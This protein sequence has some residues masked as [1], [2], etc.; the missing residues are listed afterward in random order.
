MIVLYDLL[1]MPFKLV[2]PFAVTFVCLNLSAQPVPDYSYTPT[3]SLDASGSA[4]PTIPN[5]PQSA[6]S[7]ASGTRIAY[8]DNPPCYGHAY[9][10]NWR[11]QEHRYSTHGGN[12]YSTY[13]SYI[14]AETAHG[15]YRLFADLGD[16]HSPLRQLKNSDMHDCLMIYRNADGSYSISLAYFLPE[17]G[18]PPLPVGTSL[19]LYDAPWRRY[20]WSKALCESMKLCN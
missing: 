1:R 6:L 17:I 18:E 3:P 2:L 9:L 13:N 15:H 20:I 8:V 11:W 4:P 16:P 14:L 10:I 7:L 12:Y 19:G 5:L